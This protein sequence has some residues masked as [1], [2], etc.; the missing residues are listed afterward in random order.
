MGS[1][2]GNFGHPYIEEL[3]QPEIRTNMCIVVVIN[4]FGKELQIFTIMGHSPP[5][6]NISGVFEKPS[7]SRPVAICLQPISHLAVLSYS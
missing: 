6:T 4:R 5:E 7:C 1:S 3:N 2:P